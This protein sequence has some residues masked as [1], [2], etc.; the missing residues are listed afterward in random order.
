VSEL[1]NSRLKSNTRIPPAI[2]LPMP[3]PKPM[4]HGESRSNSE[5]RGGSKPGSGPVGLVEKVDKVTATTTRDAAT[6]AE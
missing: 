5:T 1:R 4:I 6:A 3:Q 2:V